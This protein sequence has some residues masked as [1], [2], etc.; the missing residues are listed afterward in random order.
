MAAADNNVDLK[1]KADDI[2]DGAGDEEDG[3]W[4]GPMPSEA[5]KVKKRKGSPWIHHIVAHLQLMLM[6][7]NGTPANFCVC[8]VFRST[9]VWACLSGQPPISRDVWAELHAQRRYHTHS[10]FQVSQKSQGNL[11]QTGAVAR[12]LTTYK[13]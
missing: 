7:A 3:E 4:V 10:L 6:D 9:R 11:I 8:F 13:Y 5:T 1:R 12:R 2:Q